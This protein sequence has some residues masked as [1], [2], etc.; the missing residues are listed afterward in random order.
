[1]SFTLEENRGGWGVAFGQELS[2][3]YLGGRGRDMFSCTSVHL[4]D[5]R[6]QACRKPMFS[7]IFADGNN[8]RLS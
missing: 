5:A 4:D 7:R 1:M 6:H 8:A 3:G 2:G